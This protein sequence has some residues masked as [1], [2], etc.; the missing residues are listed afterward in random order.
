MIYLLLK[1]LCIHEEF[2]QNN[3]Q[4]LVLLLLTYMRMQS[5]KANMRY[6]CHL[7][8]FE[9]NLLKIKLVRCNLLVQLNYLRFD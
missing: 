1:G 6:K 4:Q 3:I 5:L 2:Y 7:D 9:P 8:D